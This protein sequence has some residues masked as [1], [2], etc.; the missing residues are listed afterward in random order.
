MGFIN[1]FITGGHHLVY[2]PYRILRLIITTNHIKSPFLLV[3]PSTGAVEFTRQG[4]KLVKV[5]A[6]TVG[7]VV[8]GLLRHDIDG[9]VTPNLLSIAAPQHVFN[10]LRSQN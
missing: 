3:K 2:F 8:M 5:N 7:E 9:I 6:L 1:Q 4:A 10:L